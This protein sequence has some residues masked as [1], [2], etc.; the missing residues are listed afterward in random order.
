MATTPDITPRSG[1]GSPFRLLNTR[2]AAAA[3]G[4]GKRTLQ[5]HVALREIAIVKIGRR[6]LFDQADL[7]DFVERHRIKSRGWKALPPARA[8]IEVAATPAG[9]EGRQ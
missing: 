9:E 1:A 2:E 4:I 8:V 7:A 5:E 6:A 3:L